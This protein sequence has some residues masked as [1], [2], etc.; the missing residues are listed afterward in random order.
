MKRTYLDT[1]QMFL[2]N[3][4]YFHLNIPA[5]YYMFVPL[6]L[7]QDL[8]HKLPLMDNTLGHEFMFQFQFP[9]YKTLSKQSI[10]TISTSLGTVDF[11][12]IGTF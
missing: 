2:P 3:L 1:Q 8:V 4:S 10:R 7:H 12:K 9:I 5:M 6:C 11:R